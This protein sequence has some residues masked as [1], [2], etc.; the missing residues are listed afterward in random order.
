MN[1]IRSRSWFLTNNYKENKV[2]TNNEVIELINQ[3]PNIKYYS[4]CLEKGEGNKE[5]TITDNDID[6]ID[7]TLHHHIYLVFNNAIQFTT[8]KSVF[9]KANIQQTKGTHKQIKKYLN[10]K[11]TKVEGSEVI[12]WGEEPLN[13]GKRTD[14]VKI[15][16]LIED[17]ADLIEIK[18][19]FPSQY[20][21]YFNKIKRA[22]E[23][24]LRHKYSK[25][26]RKLKVYYICD[27]SRTGK[28][29]FVMDRYG[30][31][32][33]CKISDYDSISRTFDNYDSQGVLLF[34]EFRDS[35]S[36]SNM[37]NYLDGYPIQLPARYFSK[38]ACYTKVFVI[39]NWSFEKQYKHESI[40]DK[41]AFVNRF[42]NIGNL[43][44][45]KEAVILDE[46]GQ[47]EIED[48][49]FIDNIFENNSTN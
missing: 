23:E 28:T 20:L 24:E 12:E 15:M 45:I 1:K 47:V 46:D 33:V 42:T 16:E 21:S 32:N 29:R 36:L 37:L 8:I 40:E 26:Y 41:E 49:S 27:K 3:L 2:L 18:K 5:S 48:C 6:H 22:I 14:I 31:E 25:E 44:E 39:S 7:G 30:Y 34:D 11:D 17:G 35:I 19:Q 13:P 4:F 9:D 10:K 43:G 38:T